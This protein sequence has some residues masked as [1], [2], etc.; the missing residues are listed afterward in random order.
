MLTIKCE[1]CGGVSRERATLGGIVTFRCGICAHE[2][3]RLREFLMKPC[4]V[5]SGMGSYVRPGF[6]ISTSYISWCGTCNA[7][8]EVPIDI[9]KE[10][11]NEF[12]EAVSQV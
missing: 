3:D 6:G 4:R 8:G 12:I 11:I 7:N 1:S 10:D 9:V 2:Q 5:C